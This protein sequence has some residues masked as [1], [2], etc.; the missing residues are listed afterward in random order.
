MNVLALKITPTYVASYQVDSLKVRSKLQELSSVTN[1]E[2]AYT[3]GV[4]TDNVA[5]KIKD[6]LLVWL[7]GIYDAKSEQ[8]LIGKTTIEY[9]TFL[10]LTLSKEQKDDDNYIKREMLGRFIEVMKKKYCV[11]NYYWRAEKKVGK[12]IHFHLIMDKYVYWKVLRWEWNKI[13]MKHGYHDEYDGNSTNMGC[14]SI[15]IDKINNAEQCAKYV[16]KYVSKDEDN[17]PIEGRIWG[18][19][20]A[21]HGVKSC[22]VMCDA[23]IQSCFVKL[24]NHKLVNVIPADSHSLIVWKYPNNLKSI[25]YELYKIYREHC[26]NYYRSLYFNKTI[27]DTRQEISRGCAKFEGKPKN[28]RPSRDDKMQFQYGMWGSDFQN[29]RKNAEMMAFDCGI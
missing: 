24:L 10:T 12:R 25:S 20:A 2:K 7:T 14:N 16:A 13:Q 21:L 15:D 3:Q 22:T 9:P 19:S 23:N 6:K 27:D 29:E 26:S 18:C 17:E 8:Q 5:R 11:I 4:M 1:F 28:V